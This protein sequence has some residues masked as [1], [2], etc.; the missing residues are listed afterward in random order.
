MYLSRLILNQ[1]SR[2]V[3][4]DLADCHDMHRTVMRAFPEKADLQ[5]GVRSHHGVL[6]RLDLNTRKGSVVL[7]VQS[8]VKPDWSKLEAGY[9]S[10]TGGNSVNL[11]CKLLTDKY[12]QITS[13]QVLRFRLRAN[14]TKKIET[15]TG[16]DGRR[17]NGRRVDLRRE[18]DQ[19]AWLHRKSMAGGFT[20]LTVR[21]VPALA[22]VQVVPEPNVM[23]LSNSGQATGQRRQQQLTF[24]AVSFEGH[25][26]VTDLKLFKKIL[27]EGVGPGKAY[28]FGLLS[29]APP[30]E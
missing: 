6:Y 27:A 30:G 15:K 17:R 26:C 9:L 14:P 12:E 5:R 4:R 19:I 8:Q 29:V 28:G 7:Y 24:G 16:P 10:E 3:R 18:E 13:G 21:A 2:S 23:S 1:A 22:E 11:A 25:L 20:L